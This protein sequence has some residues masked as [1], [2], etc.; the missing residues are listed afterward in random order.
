MANIDYT[1]TETSEGNFDLNLPLSKTVD[2]ADLLFQQVDLL[3]NTY[4]KEFLYDITQGMPYED[5]LG[6][7]FDLT[8][9]ETIYYDRISLLIYFKDLIEFKVDVDSTRTILISF[10]VV[11]LDNTIQ[12]FNQGL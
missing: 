7:D 6:Q 3:L 9:I 12:S 5:I 10:K 8:S 1:V 2:K 4:Q 11:A